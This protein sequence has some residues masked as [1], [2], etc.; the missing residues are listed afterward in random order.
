M[1]KK[2]KDFQ[3]QTK[4]EIYLQCMVII[5]KEN[6]NPEIHCKNGQYAY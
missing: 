4:T 2:I 5:F 1:G 6:T 3:F